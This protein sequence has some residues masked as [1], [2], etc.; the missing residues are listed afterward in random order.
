MGLPWTAYRDQSGRFA[1]AQEAR[2]GPAGGTRGVPQIRA[3][4]SR[5][6]AFAV[7]ANRRLWLLGQALLDDGSELRERRNGDVLRVLPAG[8]GLQGTEVGLL[9]RARQNRVGRG[10]SRI[11][12]AHQPQYLG[13]VSADQRS[14]KD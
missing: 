14:R 10:G 9:V 13:A 12:D 8:T 11:R 7:Q 2:H 3:E 4:I 6:A 1:G 5:P